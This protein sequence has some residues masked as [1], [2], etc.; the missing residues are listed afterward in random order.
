MT[1][2]PRLAVITVVG[3]LAYLG[4]AVL[5]WGLEPRDTCDTIRQFRSEFFG[6]YR[7][8]APCGNYSKL[9]GVALNDPFHS[10]LPA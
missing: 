10:L 7:P 2:T 8:S 6:R 1:L 5:G 9:A 3:T 4:L